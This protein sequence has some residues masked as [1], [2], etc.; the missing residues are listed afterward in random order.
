MIRPPCQDP[1]CRVEVLYGD[2]DSLFVRLP[3]RSLRQAFAEGRALA[4]AVSATLPWPME[5]QFEKATARAGR[6]RP[7]SRSTVS[8]YH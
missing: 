7:W 3:G 5:L 4:A 6:T 1:P 8:R 2:T